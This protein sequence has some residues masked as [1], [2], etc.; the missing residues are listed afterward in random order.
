[1]QANL[2]EGALRIALCALIVLLL[3]VA[4]CSSVARRPTERGSV[5]SQAKPAPVT[6][7]GSAVRRGGYYQDDGPGDHPPDVDSIADAEPRIEPLHRFANNPYSAFGREYVPFKELKPYRE[8]GI[9]SWYGR[10]FQ[11]LPTSSGEPYDMYAM[12][13]AHPTLPIPSYARV[14]NLAN[15]KSVIV[16]INDRGPFRSERLID[17]SWSAAAKLGY[18]EIGSATVEVE[19]IMP[20]DILAHVTQRIAPMTAEAKGSSSQGQLRT[21]AAPPQADSARAATA[22]PAAL[23][24][25]ADA[26]GV[27]LQL[28]AFS[29]RDNAEALRVRIYQS[30]PWLEQAIQILPKDGLFRLHLGPYRD[31]NEAAGIA[32]RIE[33]ALDLHALVVVR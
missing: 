14:T 7:Q 22:A 5:A 19:S 28:G 9:A 18:A 25:T 27:F 2:R 4:G 29:A 13:G 30:L 21:A 32:Q 10:K 1:M 20:A 17:L 33:S 26:A 12:T 3:G 8:R 6:Q 24:V 23:P 16:R 31:R 15:G 11:G